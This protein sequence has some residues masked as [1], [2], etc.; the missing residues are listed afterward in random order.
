MTIENIL[1]AGKNVLGTIEKKDDGGEIWRDTHG[2][3]RAYYD[4]ASDHTRAADQSILA[5]GNVLRTLVC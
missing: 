4:P 5:K 2:K 1:D 3:I